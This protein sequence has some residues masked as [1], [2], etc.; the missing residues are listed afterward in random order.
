MQVELRSS[1]LAGSLRDDADDDWWRPGFNHRMQWVLFSDAGR[2][3]NVG[4]PDGRLTYRKGDLPPFQTWK[5]D[6][7]AGVDFGGIGVYWAKA[8]RDASE[9]VRF[10]VRLEHRF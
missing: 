2:G 7:G 4:T 1:F 9:P 10:F 6:L 5:V 3:W 8:V